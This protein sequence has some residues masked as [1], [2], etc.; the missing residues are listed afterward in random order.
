MCSADIL[1]RFELRSIYG[2]DSSQGSSQSAGSSKQTLGDDDHV[3]KAALSRDPKLAKL[4]KKAE[5]AGF[6]GNS[7]IIIQFGYYCCC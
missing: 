7:V 4:W 3:L 1:N 6:S 2:V 5:L